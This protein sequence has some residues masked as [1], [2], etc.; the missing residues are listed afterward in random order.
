MTRPHPVATWSANLICPVCAGLVVAVICNV[1]MFL[2]V[3]HG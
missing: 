1:A 3:H 2:A